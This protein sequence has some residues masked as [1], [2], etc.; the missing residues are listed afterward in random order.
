MALT[1]PSIDPLGKFG[2]NWRVLSKSTQTLPNG[3]SGGKLMGSFKNYSLWACWVKWEQIDSKPTMY[4]A[5][6]HWVNDPLPPV[7]VG[8]LT[9]DVGSR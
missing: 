2:A 1:V 3:Q 5:C 9:A 8:G 7:P 4:S 6:T